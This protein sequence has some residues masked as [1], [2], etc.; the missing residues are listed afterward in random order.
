MRAVAG[1]IGWGAGFQIVVIAKGRAVSTACRRC[2]RRGT[3]CGG[4]AGHGGRRSR[5]PRRGDC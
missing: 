4:A 1:G 2:G 5:G 3:G